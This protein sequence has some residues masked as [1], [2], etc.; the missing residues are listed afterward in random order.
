MLWPHTQMAPR[1]LL[2]GGW[3]RHQAAKWLQECMAVFVKEAARA[4]RNLKGQGQD[5]GLKARLEGVWGRLGVPR[6]PYNMG[7]EELKL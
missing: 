4:K 7:A 2:S 3:Q 1:T 6:M 5:C